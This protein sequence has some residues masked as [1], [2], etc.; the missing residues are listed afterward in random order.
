MDKDRDKI[1]Q[2]QDPADALSEMA[3]RAEME[4]PSPLGRNDSSAFLEE[5]AQQ[6]EAEI[7]KEPVNPP[8]DLS[9]EETS[10]IE[11]PDEQIG[12]DLPGPYQQVGSGKDIRGNTIENTREGYKRA[13]IPFLIVLSGLLVM[14]GILA[15]VMLAKATPEERASSWYSQ[16][17][18]IV[19]ASILLAVATFFGARWLHRHVR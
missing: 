19:Y 11:N 2:R 15:I 3:D 17:K 16:M 6:S 1:E 8:E 10:L 7:D 14:I 18:M 4:T 5:L 12:E 9:A 13:L